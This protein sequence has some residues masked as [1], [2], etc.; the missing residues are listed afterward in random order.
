LGT[1]DVSGNYTIP[2][3][4]VASCAAEDLTDAQIRK[5]SDIIVITE[6]WDVLISGAANSESWMEPYDGDMSPDPANP[7]KHPMAKIAN[8]HAGGMNSAYYDG[9]A[10]WTRPSI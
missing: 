3:S 9:H 10:K 6:K 4:Y 2:R 5:P 8:W 1:K 7:A